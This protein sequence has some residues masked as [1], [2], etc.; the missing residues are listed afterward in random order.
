ML[1][2]YIV[3]LIIIILVVIFAVQNVDTVRMKLWF[4]DLDASLSLVI[5]LTFAAGG[6]VTLVLAMY[7]LNKRNRKISELEK[8]QNSS[9]KE[10]KSA[11]LFSNE[12]DSLT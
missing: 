7:E 6:L 9:K 12:K 3:T 4:F 5:I 2:R 11:D 1:K 8:Q 10:S